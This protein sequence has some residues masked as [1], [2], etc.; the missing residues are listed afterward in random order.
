MTAT[1]PAP[2]S[3][4]DAR[5]ATVLSCAITVFA[6]TGYYAT[7][8]TEVADAAKISPAYVFRLFPSKLALFVAALDE[9]FRRVLRS[10]AEGADA[11]DAEDPEAVLAAMGDAYA[12]LI[13]DRS[14]LMLQVHALSAGDVPEIRAALQRGLEQVVTRAAEHTGAPQDAVQRFMA[15][16]QLCHLIV[17]AGLVDLTPS[18]ATTL[19]AGMAHPAS[20][21]APAPAGGGPAGGGR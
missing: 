13:A 15:Y 1:T 20:A 11:S 3:T 4:A 12:R 5:R 17:A 21:P 2:R 14:L 7:P 9:C 19:T 8:V 18:W 10:L 16:G 6:R